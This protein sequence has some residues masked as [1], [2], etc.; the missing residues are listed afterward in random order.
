MQIKFVLKCEC[1][2]KLLQPA[3]SIKVSPGPPLCCSKC[4]ICIQNLRSTACLS[5]KPSADT[6]NKFPSY[7]N[8]TNVTNI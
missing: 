4:P 5:Y 7:R 1:S 2:R 3:D 8:A 6:F